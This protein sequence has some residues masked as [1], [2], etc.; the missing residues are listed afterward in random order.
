ME[1]MWITVENQRDSGDFVLGISQGGIKSLLQSDFSP[2]PSPQL[3]TEPFLQMNILVRK[4]SCNYKAVI[5]FSHK[6]TVVI[7]TNFIYK[8]FPKR[9]LEV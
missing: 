6:L 4:V 2:Q 1:N 7:T 3:F 9:V 5:R 8:T